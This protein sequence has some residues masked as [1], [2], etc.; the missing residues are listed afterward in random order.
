MFEKWLFPALLIILGVGL[1]FAGI[2]L[3]EADDSPGAGM[4]GLLLMVVVVSL[5]VRIAWRR[6]SRGSGG[7]ATRLTD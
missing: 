6:R 7:G 5:G 3:G 2:T 4:L 1:G